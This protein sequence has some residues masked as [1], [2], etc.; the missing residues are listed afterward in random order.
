MCTTF[1]TFDYTSKIKI[2]EI[3]VLKFTYCALCLQYSWKLLHPTDHHQNTDC[4]QNAEEYERVCL[5][6]F[7][8]VFNQ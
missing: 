2:R 3:E 8:R 4:P 1:Y 6:H 5:S 7:S